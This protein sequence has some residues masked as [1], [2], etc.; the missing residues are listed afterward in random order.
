MKKT[1]YILIFIIVIIAG[2]VMIA[3]NPLS[4]LSPAQEAPASKVDV[5]FTV[6]DQPVKIQTIPFENVA[7]T[8]QYTGVNWESENARNAS[9]TSKKT[10]KVYLIEGHHLDANASAATWFCVITQPSGASI[11]SYDNRATRVSPWSGK[12]PD[13]EIDLA[14]I[15]TPGELFAKNR[16]TI[17]KDTGS[18]NEETR[19]LS[20]TAGTYYL[21][22][23][24]NDKTRDLEFDAKTGALISTN[25]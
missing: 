9:E 5:G 1:A 8:I 18:V 6:I 11:V 19:D 7:D 2:I 12:F 24:G 25:D 17:F 15:I 16:N 13:K 20:L 10:T 23:K 14:G 21:T 4:L 22:I 3:G